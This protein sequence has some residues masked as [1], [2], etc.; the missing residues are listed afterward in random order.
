M[1]NRILANAVGYLNALVAIA[2]IV[3][4]SLIFAPDNYLVGAIIGFIGALIACG[5]IALF[6]D[7]RIELIRIRE[8]LEKL[9]ALPRSIP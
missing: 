2:F 5:L 4:G 7:M 1:V 3:T 8:A 9:A 6:I